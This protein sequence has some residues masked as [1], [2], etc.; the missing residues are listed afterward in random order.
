MRIHRFVFC[1]IAGVVR[2]VCHSYA[3]ARA[4]KTYAGRMSETRAAVVL[5]PAK[6]SSD[7]TATGAELTYLQVDAQTEIAGKVGE[8]ARILGGRNGFIVLP[9]I[10]K[11][12]VALGIVLLMVGCAV[13]PDFKRP[14]APAAKEY[15]SHP[16]PADVEPGG[17][18]GAPQHFVQ[19]MDIPAQW[20]TL[21]HSPSLNRL[22]EQA[23]KAN[24]TLKAAEATL[25]QAQENV[26][27]AEGALFPSVNANGA[28]SRQKTN[29]ATAGKAGPGPLFTLYNAS[30]SV[31]YGIDIF[32]TARRTLEA[33]GAQADFERFQMKAATLTLTS[34][35]VTTAVQ[36]A[37]LQAQIAATREIVDV[38]S[39]QLD[40]LQHQSN[41]GAVSLASVLAQ[42]TTL[43]QTR[44]NLP[45]LEKQLA[46]IHNQ[47]AALAGHF[48]SQ[49]GGV[50]FDLDSL[51]LPQ[52]LPVSLP[53]M[54]VKQRPDIRASESQLHA[55][56]AEIG[57]ATANMFPQF[58]ISG[59]AGSVA[60]A[61]GNLFTAGSG[62][63]DAVA[64]L[65]Q[66]IFHGGTL[67]HQR[68]A[69][70][71]A[72]AAAEAQYRSTVLSAFQDVAN[73]LDALQFDATILQAQQTA[74]QSAAEYLDIARQQYQSGAISFIA[75][76]NAQQ[77]YQ[78]TRIALVQARAS[79][80]TDTA[81]LFASLGGGWWSRKDADMDKQPGAD[82]P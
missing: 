80:Y 14:A 66:P 7:A 62:I 44:A 47:L 23:L 54:L 68:R 53:S 24:P 49:D 11:I 73:V 16:L 40:V 2:S 8:M 60:N 4:A 33:I 39:Q 69:A 41:V 19:N 17:G 21:F 15:T 31:S 58:T 81:A 5:N 29:G 1:P 6:V 38:Q 25:R 76:L 43:A 51:Q 79:R 34:N 30:V 72:Y 28:V 74:A 71:A 50:T 45:V 12:T 36:E 65:T 18:G 70:V 52:E 37:S 46:L 3:D 61:A 10:R 56:S 9:P 64:G 77:A 57:V 26:Y 42:K 22:V 78:Q 63:W 59:S 35:V 55:A 75:L 67:L 13:G 32:G 20:W 82:K 48:P 27:A